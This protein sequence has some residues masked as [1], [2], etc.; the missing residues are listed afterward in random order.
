MKNNPK[1]DYADDP[2]SRFYF[3]KDRKKSDVVEF[4]SRETSVIDESQLYKDLRKDSLSSQE[5]FK[6]YIEEQAMNCK[7]AKVY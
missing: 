2:K 7:R 1:R 6:I 5:N 3:K 4:T